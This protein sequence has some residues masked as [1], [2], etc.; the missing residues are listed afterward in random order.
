M[1]Y[2]ELSREEQIRYGESALDF[3]NNP[4]AQQAIKDLSERYVRMWDS[5]TDMEEREK[6]WVWR[7]QLAVV[8]NQFK[9]LVDNMTY[10]KS[11]EES[12]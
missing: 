2:K 12:K 4:V 5:A 1:N 10:L 6:L 7:Q 9:M 3:L 8:V 11:E